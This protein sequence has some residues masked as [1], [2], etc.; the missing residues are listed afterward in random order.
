[1]KYLLYKSF[2]FFLIFAM[3]TIFIIP[4]NAD[5]IPLQGLDE[6][7]NILY[8]QGSNLAIIEKI[9]SLE[10]VLFGHK[11]KGSLANRAQEIINYI[12]ST[13]RD[14]SLFLIINTMEWTLFN[15]YNQGPLIERIEGLEKAVFASV[16]EG[17]LLD[18]IEHLSSL[19]IS[20]D[21][22][23]LGKIILE[24]GYEVNIR[25][26][27]EINTTSNKAGDVI[28]FI[29]ENNVRLDNYLM[30]PSGTSGSLVL[31]EVKEARG[32]GR[33]A[34]IAMIINDI[35]SIN[36]EGVPLTLSVEEDQGSHSAEVA[37]GVSFLSTIIVSNP[38]GLVAGYF[39][40]GRDIQLPEGT[41]MTIQVREDVELSGVRF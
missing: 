35:V 32:F 19:L 29:V 36:G 39:Y 40:R 1:M 9:E 31:T 41:V 17:A 3:T 30:I 20:V 22:L 21:N 11:N 4:V 10:T 38:I 28:N 37:V 12:Y 14:I 8:G 26:K 15:S 18:R 7:E 23:D 27:D 34:T 24:Q 25:L 2:L 5:I 16:Q 33:D 6:V 13:E